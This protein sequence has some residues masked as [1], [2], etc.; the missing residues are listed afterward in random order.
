MRHKVVTGIPDCMQ[1]QVIS[2]DRCVGES[3]RRALTCCP[4]NEMLPIATHEKSL[5]LAAE[6][7]VLLCVWDELQLQNLIWGKIRS[8]YCNPIVVL[9]AWKEKSF[10]KKQPAF[11]GEKGEITTINSHAYVRLPVKLS[12]LARR[13]EN[14]EP[15]TNLRVVLKDFQNQI[16]YLNHRVHCI[17]GPT[18]SLSREDTLSRLEE[19]QDYLESKG[20]IEKS[21]ELAAGI[22]GLGK[23]DWVA[24]ARR[25]RTMCEDFLGEPQAD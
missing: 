25:L 12:T 9:G 1:I 16:N 21:K 23:H 13:I 8:K 6:A 10:G 11:N 15:V 7:R 24:G 4:G 20:A 2:D 14:L 22:A 18:P 19:V 17:N 3:L 5:K